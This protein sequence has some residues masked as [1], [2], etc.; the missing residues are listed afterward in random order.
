MYYD[1]PQ[2]KCKQ[3]EYELDEMFRIF[4]IRIKKLANSGG[5][6]A[7]RKDDF[8]V[9]SP[10]ENT[11]NERR[12]GVAVVLSSSAARDRTKSKLPCVRV[13]LRFES[14]QT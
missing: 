6:L 10:E 2:E 4:G 12:R 11:Q 9:R 13:T 1:L 3:L 7:S 14:P 5:G 8:S